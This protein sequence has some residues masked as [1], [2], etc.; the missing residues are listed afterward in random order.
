MNFN[1]IDYC[2]ERDI[3][4][5]TLTRIMSKAFVRT[6]AEKQYRNVELCM[7]SMALGSHGEDM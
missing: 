7:G 3:D 6:L 5:V 1:A 4:L 2:F